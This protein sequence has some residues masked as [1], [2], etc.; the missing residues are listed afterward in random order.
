MRTKTST[1]T[2]LALCIGIITPAF[3]HADEANDLITKI[4]SS[5]PTEKAKATKYRSQASSQKKGGEASNAL[6]IPESQL[7]EASAKFAGDVTGKYIYGPVTLKGIK[8]MMGEPCVELT[9]K[10]MRIF[11]LYTRDPS[12][13]A[14]FNSGWGTP[15]NIPKSFPLRI[16]GKPLPG[17]YSVRMPYDQDKTNHGFGEL[18]NNA[19]INAAS[20]Q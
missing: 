20:P 10:N 14:A 13:I 11:L 7:V 16:V 17:M 9:A 18:L 3:L 15:Y 4:L 2:I 19:L 12:V 1:S 5:S 6:G 8:V